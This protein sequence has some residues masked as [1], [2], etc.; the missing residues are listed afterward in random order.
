MPPSGRRSTA[1]SPP[2]SAARSR[3][4]S[5]P[6]PARGASGTPR[7]SSVTS[8]VSWLPA[9]EPDP[10]RARPGVADGVGHRLDGDPVR[11]DL[12]RRRQL[13]QLDAARTRRGSTPPRRC[14]VRAP[15]ESRRLMAD[16]AGEAQLVERRRPQPVDQ[17]P[18][19]G[20]RLADLG[21]QRLQLPSRRRG[22]VVD[23]R[24]RRLG[25]HPD[26][27]ERR[28]RDRRG[29]R[30]RSRRRSSSRATTSRS[31]DRA[32]ASRSCC[33]WIAAPAWR[34]RSWRSASSS[35]RKPRSPL[36]T[37]S[38]RRPTGSAPWT[39]AIAWT[40]ATGVPCS[41]TTWL[42]PTSSVTSTTTYGRRSASA[43]V[44]AMAGKARSGLRRPT[45]A[46]SRGAASPAAARRAG[47]TS[48]G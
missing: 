5:R 20:E 36:R 41:A 39:R 43:T 21:A 42:P 15:V 33:A 31:R 34:A 40:S 25:P 3:I 23:H 17:P 27:R 22:V 29:G 9:C 19:V 12:D 16:R 44:S 45:R 4:D 32:S 8:T 13:G 7:P 2:T 46:A 30:V 38:T 10:A 28:A 6:V 1:T 35:G 14:A 47:R 18:D 48:A 11:G 26:R 37:P 24:R